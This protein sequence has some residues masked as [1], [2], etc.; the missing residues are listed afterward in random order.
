MVFASANEVVVYKQDDFFPDLS[1]LSNDI[2]DGPVAVRASIERGNA[3]EDAIQRA[4][5]RGLY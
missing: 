2:I 3:A 1:Q 4:T 5:T